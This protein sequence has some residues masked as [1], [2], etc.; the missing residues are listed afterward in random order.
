MST[1][2]DTLP[3]VLLRPGEADRIIAGHPWV[4]QNEVL[5]TTDIVKDGELVPDFDDEIV[6]GMCVVRAGE[7]V[8]GPTAEAM[9]LT[10]ATPA[11]APAPAPAAPEKS[12]SDSDGAE[13]A[14][15]QKGAGA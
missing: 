7:V 14:D 3:T 12:E 4:Y 8:H 11:Q 1:I 13:G 15:E 5:R 9:G 2:I 10:P 6:A